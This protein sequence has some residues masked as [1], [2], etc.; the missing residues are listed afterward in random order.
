[1]ALLALVHMAA[2]ALR[3]LSVV[4]RSVWLSAAGG[5]SVAYVFVHLLPE[6]AAG[7]RDVGEEVTG[8]LARVEDHVYLVALAGL[9]VFYGVEWT[10]RR[11]REARRA[12]EGEDRTEARAF[13]FSIAAFAVYNGLI[14][15][16]LVHRE[17]ETTR[18][19][20]LFAVALG[21][22]FLVTD[23]GLIR[24][25]GAD[26][27]RLG[28][29]LLV[30]AVVAGWAIGLATEISDAALAVLIAFLGGGV[31]LNVLKEEVPTEQQARFVPFLLGAAGYSA[32]LLAA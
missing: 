26:F 3:V 25:H 1:M 17:Q 24:H 23:A 19:L 11:S 2:P 9:A 27:H 12:R 7:Q 8:A 14:G 30:A 20:I 22:H 4:P 6:L 31:V 5:I 21:V 16:I 10:S 13:W 29:W 28:R 15:Y 32:L 18:A